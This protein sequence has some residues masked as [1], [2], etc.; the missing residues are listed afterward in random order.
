MP[1]GA[2]NIVCRNLDSFHHCKD[3][4]SFTTSVLLVQGYLTQAEKMSSPVDN[5]MQ[6]RMTSS[7]TKDTS[8]ISCE[9]H[10]MF[11]DLLICDANLPVA[12][13]P[14]SLIH[15]EVALFDRGAGQ[16]AWQ[17]SLKHFSQSSW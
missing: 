12:C 7:S 4:C 10:L 5:S 13:W 2:E 17:P 16:P 14:V 9:S 11:I 6:K 3:R 1:P 15:L 8:A